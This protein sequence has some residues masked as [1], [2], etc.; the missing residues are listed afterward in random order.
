MSKLQINLDTIYTS[1]NGLKYKIIK[2][3][4]IIDNYHKVRIKF[5]NSGYEYDAI[6]AN[7]KNGA[8]RDPLNGIYFD[9]IY[10]SNSYGDYKIIKSYHNTNSKTHMVDIQF[11]KTGFIKHVRAEHAINGSVKD[12]YFPSIYGVGYYGE[13]ENGKV[14]W[15]Y[16][17]W[18][19][20]LSRC[21][22]INDTHYKSYGM[23]GVGVC[24]RW[25]NYSNFFIDIS[26]LNGYENKIQYPN[27][28]ELD[29]DFLQSHIPKNLRIYSPET[30]I[31]IHKELNNAL[32][33]N[34]Y[35]LSKD[36]LI[37]PLISL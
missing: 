35:N 24:T 25:H 27:L 26:K 14:V 34:K 30:C 11:L 23:I 37:N 6:Y 7:V 31:F 19:H 18:K 29:K 13:I 17:M 3:L 28:Y 10:S 16:N 2:D 12:P 8:V 20:M 1:K 33:Y 4:G 21:Y 32:R 22:N 36:K 5:I 9:T 15:I